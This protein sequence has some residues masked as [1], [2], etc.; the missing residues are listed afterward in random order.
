LD[1]G[2]PLS[3]ATATFSIRRFWVLAKNFAIDFA[4]F[5][6]ATHTVL[7]SQAQV[8][9]CSRRLFIKSKK[10][11]HIY[12][13]VNEL[14]FNDL[15]GDIPQELQNWEGRTGY[16]LFRGKYNLEAGLEKIVE[17]LSDHEF[18]GFAVI[19]TDA[20]PFQIPSSAKLIVIERRLSEDEIKYLY[21]NAKFSISQLS[22]KSRLERTIPHKV[23][24]SI[25]FNCPV[26]SYKTKPIME[27]FQS[28]ENFIE[29]SKEF[30]NYEIVHELNS[31]F[32]N[33]GRL[34]KLRANL[35]PE[36]TQQISQ[37]N[38]SNQL[39]DLAMSLIRSS[40]RSSNQH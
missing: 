1:A 13:G 20:L 8:E 14:T 5:H 40:T 32:S 15:E 17:V 9:A 18:K 3:D 4:S 10:L 27:I 33:P 29:I 39:Y 37:K 19:C 30:K 7:E 21:L 31:F 6:L 38:L 2:W 26:M 23:Y 28:E 16:V 36:L 25:Y 12:T 34:A 35:S 24:E 22:E 11:S